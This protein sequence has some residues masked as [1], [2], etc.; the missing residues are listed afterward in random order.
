MVNMCL[1]YSRSRSG[2]PSV[3]TPGM[4]DKVQP[5]PQYNADR[6]RGFGSTAAAYVVIVVRGTARG[7]SL[8]PIIIIIDDT[9]HPSFRVTRHN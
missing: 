4:A 7:V 5:K 2:A 1:D 8:H 3:T 6:C 9:H